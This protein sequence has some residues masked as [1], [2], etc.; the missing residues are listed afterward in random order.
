MLTRGTVAEMED[1]IRAE[2]AK[3]F[4][5]SEGG[6]TRA[7]WVQTLQVVGVPEFVQMLESGSMMDDAQISACRVL[8]ARMFATEVGRRVGLDLQ[9]SDGLGRVLGYLDRMGDREDDSEL[10]P[11][12]ARRKSALVDRGWRLDE[13]V[14]VSGRHSLKTQSAIWHKRRT[15]DSLGTDREI[16]RHGASREVEFLK[17]VATDLGR[18]DYNEGLDLGAVNR[19]EADWESNE[20]CELGLVEFVERMVDEEALSR[21]DKQAVISMQTQLVNLLR[22]AQAVPTVEECMSFFSDERNGYIEE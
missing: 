12:L 16:Y 11:L 18:Y 3:A 4:K 22:D 6:C 1:A 7:S 9:A 2:V 13:S 21:V 8:V 17:A 19:P 14:E 15:G 5:T 10:L 20:A